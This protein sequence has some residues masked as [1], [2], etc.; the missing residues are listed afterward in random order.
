MR[1]TIEGAGA[2][3]RQEPKENERPMDEDTIRKGLIEAGAVDVFGREVRTVKVTDIEVREDGEG[4]DATPHLVG[5]AAVFNQETVIG[6][7]FREEIA[8]GAF[9]K[10]LKDGADVRHLFNHNPD[11]VLA[12]TKSK[13]LELAEDKT[14]LAFD[15][16]L[17]MD[18]PDA[19]RVVAKVERGDVDQSSFAFLPVRVEWEEAS[20]DPDTGTK[21]LPKRI[22][23]EAKLFD[24]STV[25]YP[26][27]E[28]AETMLRAAAVGVLEQATG[29]DSE[30]MTKILRGL[31]SDQLDPELAP[32]LAQASTALAELADQCR[33]GEASSRDDDAPAAEKAPGEEPAAEKAPDAGN[34]DEALEGW[35]RKAQA[36]LILEAREKGLSIG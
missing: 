11:M 7:W 24:T 1:V 9:K 30:T 32:S 25:T 6:G 4:E 8:P 14:G 34:E 18:D 12:R 13:T 2:T 22:I 3:A 17:N 19:V 5:H 31:T 21:L 27:Y 10:T 28:A 26:A 15:A 20:V 36:Q 35:R 23:R 16:E 33:E 29:L